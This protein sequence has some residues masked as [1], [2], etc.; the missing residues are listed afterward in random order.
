[1]STRTIWT[2]LIDVGQIS[3]F[4]ERFNISESDLEC[5]I[6][7]EETSSGF[8][9]EYRV[10]MVRKTVS[11][12]KSHKARKQVL[13]VLSLGEVWEL[14]NKNAFLHYEYDSSTIPIRL[15]TRRLE[16]LRNSQVCC[17]CGLEG[18]HFVIEKFVA[19]RGLH[20]NMYADNGCLMTQDHKVPRSRGGGSDLSNLQTMCA[21]CNQLKGNKLEE[22]LRPHDFQ[23]RR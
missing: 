5:P 2:R 9:T 22:E 11:S 15:G 4:M 12:A 23:R 13:K 16:C 14:M 17:K 8:V 10:F 19:D 7:P 1:M 18:T 6:E 21:T 3:G 20:L